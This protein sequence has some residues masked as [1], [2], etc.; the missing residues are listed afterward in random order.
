MMTCGLLVELEAARDQVA[1]VERFLEEALPLVRTEPETA[2]WFALR[3]RRYHYG[4][5]DAFPNEA[6]RERHLHGPVAQALGERS[7]LFARAPV[8]HKVEILGDKLPT[9]ALAERDQKALLFRVRPR[10][11]RE[12]DLADFMRATR[13]IV[14]AEPDTT[15][16]FALRFE[17]GDLGFFDA[18]PDSSARRKHMLGKAPRGLLKRIALLGSIPRGSFV[19]VQAENFAS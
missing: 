4:I 10:R 2:A 1:S 19:D 15:A 6:A 18:F 11:G 7:A 16:W 13:S 8:I 9:T 17:N 14:D 5:L 3:F 12:E